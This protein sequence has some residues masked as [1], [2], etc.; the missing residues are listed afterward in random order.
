[1]CSSYIGIPSNSWVDDYIDW[2]NP[3]SKCCRLYSSGLNFGKFCPASQRE[4]HLSETTLKYTKCLH[5]LHDYTNPYSSTF[6]SQQLLP[7]VFLIV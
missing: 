6:V 4:K 3:G 5:D 2:L 7:N 1:M